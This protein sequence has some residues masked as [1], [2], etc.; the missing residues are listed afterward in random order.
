MKLQVTGLRRGLRGETALL[1]F[2]DPVEFEALKRELEAEFAPAGARERLAFEGIV[3]NAWRLGRARMYDAALGS[4]KFVAAHARR[5]GGETLYSLGAM[6]SEDA[7]RNRSL[8]YALNMEARFELA[9]GR[10]VAELARLQE[11]RRGEP[12]KYSAAPS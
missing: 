1:P 11:A 7:R 12:R 8:E 4:Q 10:S 3:L 9:Y 6:L 5:Y 2:E